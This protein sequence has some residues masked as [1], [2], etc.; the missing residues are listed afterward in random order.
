M[1]KMGFPLE[2]PICLRDRGG[3][4]RIERHVHPTPRRT[5]PQTVALLTDTC[6]WRRPVEWLLDVAVSWDVSQGI[7]PDDV[8]RYVS[9]APMRREL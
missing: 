4:V 7:F 1:L 5:A 8:K 9:L 2:P 3:V 6:F